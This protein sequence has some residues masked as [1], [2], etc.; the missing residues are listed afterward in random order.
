MQ[1]A[2]YFH[3]YYESVAKLEMLLSSKETGWKVPGYSLDLMHREVQVSD[4]VF[5]LETSMNQRF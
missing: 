3:S 4:Y 2:G 5:S 1:N